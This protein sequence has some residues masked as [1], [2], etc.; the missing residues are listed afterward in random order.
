MGGA[1]RDDVRTWPRQPDQL[2]CPPDDPLPEIRH[3]RVHGSVDGRGHR[4]PGF[5]SFALVYMAFLAFGWWAWE[6][7]SGVSALDWYI[8]V[9]WTLPVVTSSMGL[10]GGLRTARLQRHRSQPPVPPTVQDMLVVVVPTIGR[11]DTYPALERVVRSFCR[12]L[13]S[14]FPRLRIDLLIE[15]VCQARNEI[16]GLADPSIRVITIPRDYRT[17]NG[18]R[19]KARANHYAHALRL[20]EGEAR[21]DVWVLHMDDD[22][23]VGSDTARELASFIS[24]QRSA[25]KRALHLAQGVLCFPREYAKNRLTWLADAVRPGC[26]IGL[27]AATTGRGSPRAGLHGELLLVRASVEATIG[28]DFGARTIVEDAQF[29]LCF[30]DRYAGRSGWIPGCSYGAS[31]ATVSDFVR[32]R[33][34]WVWG[35]LELAIERKVPLRRRLFLIHNVAVWLCAAIAQPALILLVGVIVGDVHANPAS[36]VLIPLWALNIAFCAWL[37]WEGLKLNI[38]SSARPGPLW[39]D[40]LCLVALAPLFSVWEVAGISCGLARFLLRGETRFT[41]IRKPA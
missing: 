11:R 14:Y 19:F 12:E 9:V 5:I 20:A 23:G 3:G 1:L 15:E 39:W 8:S 26:D 33:E 27:F 17:P 24:A 21:D 4:G 36:P 31:P 37:Y 2:T 25:G 30:C 41:V 7:R 6:R 35:L 29:A 40:R 10:V 13:P 22:T 38:R 16:F 18:T 32:Q 28:W 34:R